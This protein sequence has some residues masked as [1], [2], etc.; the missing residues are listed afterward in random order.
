M[1]RPTL[2][3][4]LAMLLALFAPAVI[5]EAE[6]MMMDTADEDPAMMAEATETQVMMDTAAEDPVMMAEAT[7]TEVMTDT[8]AEMPAR[9]ARGLSL[10]HI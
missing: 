2:F 3:L 7:E 9:M 8:P 5:A 6:T 10:I 4:L 1:A